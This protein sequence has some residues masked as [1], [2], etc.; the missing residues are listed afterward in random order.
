MAVTA[1]EPLSPA[2]ADLVR[3][4]AQALVAEP[5]RVFTEV[6][7]AVLGAL[8]VIAADDELTAEVRATDHANI[9]RWLTAMAQRPG[10]TV[11]P[12]VTPEA[13]EIARDVVRRGLDREVL[14]TG[15]RLGQ[16]ALWRAWM[17]EL[18]AQAAARPPWSAVLAE[19]LE[20][21]ARSLFDF[22]DDVLVNVDAQVGRE[23][24]QLLG[25]GLA[26][27][28]ETVQ[29]VLEG[30]PITEQRASARLGYELRRDHVAV[31]L[32][33]TEAEAGH[34][35]LER[36]AEVVTRALGAVRPLTVPL[37]TT[38]M[39]AWAPASGDPDGEA[40]R[41]ALT[42][43]GLRDV[44][45]AV[46]SP[47]TGIAGFRRSH[48]EALDVQRLARRRPG[49]ARVTTY[50]EVEVAV[51][52]GA[53]AER[54]QRFVE[55]TLGPLLGAK[56]ELR[57]TLRVHLQEQGSATRAATRLFTHRNTV[58]NR[59]ARAQA[60]L[61]RPVV[62]RLLPVALALELDHWLASGASDVAPLEDDRR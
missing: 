36:T 38:A 5:A 15:Y 53:H 49:C 40:L 18:T 9:T 41:T 7:A 56:P 23:R 35:V 30:A 55:R 28:V 33:T 44:H 19:A 47:A 62:D 60:L 45:V 22:I 59:V 31:V 2:A 57:E 14:W 11:G 1:V 48:E 20:A 24:D 6:D 54:A 16:N 58:L 4:A 8:P 32:W 10:G 43:A 34:G 29:L 3:A 37:G 17:R 51:L 52:A 26:Q 46:G 39:W 21:T 50:E 42:Q 25:G 27:R 12:D 13:L 61:P